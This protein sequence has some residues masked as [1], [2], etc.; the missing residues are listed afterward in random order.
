MSEC[1]CFN[2]SSQGEEGDK[3]NKTRGLPMYSNTAQGMPINNSKKV[4]IHCTH[5]SILHSVC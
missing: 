5:M 2:F 1:V 4:H 3:S